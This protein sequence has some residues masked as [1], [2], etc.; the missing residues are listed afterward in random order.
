MYCL[1]LV[2]SKLDTKTEEAYDWKLSSLVRFAAAADA[3]Q[4]K[5]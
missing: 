3:E 5:A 2:K 4:D 1:D